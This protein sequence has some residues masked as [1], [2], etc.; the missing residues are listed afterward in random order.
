MRSNSRGP[1][2]GHCPRGEFPMFD[3]MM[4][5]IPLGF[6]MVALGYV[7]ACDRM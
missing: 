2:S 4:I 7:V 1:L 3:V 6:F 5:A